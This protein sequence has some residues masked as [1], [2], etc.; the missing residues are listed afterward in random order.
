M[1]IYAANILV[2]AALRFTVGSCRIKNVGGVWPDRRW[3]RGTASALLEVAM[4]SPFQG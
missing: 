1:G 2:F 3:A 4:Q